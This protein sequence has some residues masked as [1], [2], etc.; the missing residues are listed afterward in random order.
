MK[1][2]F[3][4]IPLNWDVVPSFFFHSC[5][6][7]QRYAIGKYDFNILTSKTAYLD[8]MRY[9]LVTMALSHD[10]DYILWLDADQI[11]P[12]DT[13]EILM[14]HIDS[15]KMVAG[16]VTPH[17]GSGIPLVY[18]IQ[19]NSEC[20]YSKDVRPESGIHKVD[21]M[22][23]GGVMMNPEVFKKVGA[24]CFQMYWDKETNN[25][26]GED[27]VF[28]KQCK[29]KGIDVWCDTDL[30]FDHLVVGGIG[31]ADLPPPEKSPRLWIPGQARG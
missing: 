24:D 22:G 19:D 25:K 4:C 27:V 16:G 26:I 12:K 6:L 8:I 5:C 13:P 17:R 1:K 20:R 29:E 3:V 10:P 23:F 11:Y 30:L 31:F 21:G 28:Y 2:I 15:G 14:K 7:M 18:D 9:Q